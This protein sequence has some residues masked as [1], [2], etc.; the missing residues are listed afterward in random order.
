MFT[1]FPRI[2]A[3][4]GI[5]ILLEDKCPPSLLLYWGSGSNLFTTRFK[6][7]VLGISM[8]HDNVQVKIEGILLVGDKGI[9][10]SPSHSLSSDPVS[11]LVENN[12]SKLCSDWLTTQGVWLERNSFGVPWYLWYQS[13]STRS[14][15]KNIVYEIRQFCLPI[16]CWDR[17]LNFMSQDVACRQQSKLHK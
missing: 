7:F 9:L 17:R 8:T 15:C 3:E 16:N 2:T 4:H 12:W 13:R 10:I 14:W 11:S 5:H 6:L 1:R